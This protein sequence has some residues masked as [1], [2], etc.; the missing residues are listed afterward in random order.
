VSASSGKILGLGLS[1]TLEQTVPLRRDE[2]LLPSARGSLSIG[3]SYQ[4]TRAIVPTNEGI[5]R[6]STDASD[7]YGR[8]VPSD[9]LGGA[10]F[11]QHQ[12]TVALGA[13][14]DISE[15]VTFDVQFGWRPAYKYQLDD[16]AQVC[17]LTGCVTPEPARDA[18]HFSV[19]SLFQTELVVDAPAPVGF[20]FGYENVTLQLAP[21]GQRR[22]MLYSPDA[23]VYASLI[24]HLDDLYGYAKGNS[25]PGR[26]A[27]A[28]RAFPWQ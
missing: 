18:Q 12:G 20:A 6:F 19:I 2:A 23:R 24:V 1:A 15:K 11:A 16:R 14:L 7:P 8:S 25:A 9:Q 5:E 22:N 13:G 26:S 28:A 21:N 17:V 4:F 10:A 27:A 3:Y